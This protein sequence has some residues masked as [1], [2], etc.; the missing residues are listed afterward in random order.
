MNKQIHNPVTG[1]GYPLKKSNSTKSK[2]KGLWSKSMQKPPILTD[3]QMLFALLPGDDNKESRVA[4]G[5]TPGQRRIAEAQRNDTFR[6]TLKMV[7]SLLTPQYSRDVPDVVSHYTLQPYNVEALNRLADQ[8]L[9]LQI[10]EERVCEECWGVGSQEIND[11]GYKVLRSTC[12]N[13]H[14]TGKL[15]GKTV[16]QVLEEYDA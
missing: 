3:E 7:L 6:E 1:T 12:P 8:I 10:S 2:V 15:P 13:C 11:A 16:G 14:G 9:N 4:S 5:V